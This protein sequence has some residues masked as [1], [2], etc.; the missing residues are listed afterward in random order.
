MFTFV[1]SKAPV[2]SA[3]TILLLVVMMLQS[4]SKILIVLNY[5]A[6][7]NFI[8]EY[9]CVNKEKP[10]LHCQG[11]CYL[12]KELK[13]AEQA[14]EQPN[15]QNQK[16]TLEITLFYQELFSLTPN[17]GKRLLPPLPL[18]QTGTLY[19]L[20]SAIFHPPRFTV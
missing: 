18:Y 15:S 20:N 9:L 2:K 17:Y 10:Q 13:K 6:N 11:H 14:G 7:K 16:Q 5:Q 1:S 19:L 12:K 8:A 3:L 4:F